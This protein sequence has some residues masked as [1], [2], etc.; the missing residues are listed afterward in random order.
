MTCSS[1]RKFSFSPEVLLQEQCHCVMAVPGLPTSVAL[2]SNEF[3]FVRDFTVR[4]WAAGEPGCWTVPLAACATAHGCATPG[5]VP[6]QLQPPSMAQLRRVPSVR[7]FSL[8]S[9]RSLLLLLLLRS[10]FQ[11]SKPHPAL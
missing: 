7:F 9:F 10:R 1:H 6:V 4:T 11:R 2:L 8:F 5:V 3:V